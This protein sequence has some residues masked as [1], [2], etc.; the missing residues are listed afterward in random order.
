MDKLLPTKDV[1]LQLV[2][3][4]YQD[5]QHTNASRPSGS[6]SAGFAW[7]ID[8]SIRVMGTNLDDS[9]TGF[10][11]VHGVDQMLLQRRLLQLHVWQSR[12]RLLTTL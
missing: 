12:S 3:S 6:F 5:G 2:R 1:L 11:V 10:Q 9:S 8:Q 4:R 7:T